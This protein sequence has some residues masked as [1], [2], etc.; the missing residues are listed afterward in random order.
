MIYNN[1]DNLK[2]ATADWSAWL[3]LF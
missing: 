1:H 3:L 2:L